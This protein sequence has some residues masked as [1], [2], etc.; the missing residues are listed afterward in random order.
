MNRTVAHIA[1][2]PGVGRL[3]RH[4]EH[5]ERSRC[6][7]AAPRFGVL[8]SVQ[9]DRHCDPFDQGDIGSCTGNAMAGACMTG[10]LFRPGRVLT[11]ANAVALYEAA[12]RLDGITGH[13]PPDD[14]GS[15]GLAVAKAAQRAGLISAYHHAFG[16]T[17]S[18]RALAGG[19]VI[20][21]VNWYE[22]F[23]APQGG[24]A[25]LVVSGV[26]RGGHELVL[27]GLDVE[28]GFVHGTNSWGMWGNRGK[29]VMSF[30]TFKRLLAE[31]GDVVAP[32]A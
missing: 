10:P 9:W 19:P 3:G 1:E 4:V 11:E 8:K 6:F 2:H 23:D 30:G 16:L 29:F 24:A 28:A 18:L 20:I 32:V 17:A 27:D 25:E 31:R 22:G 12:T 13:Y 7:A 21:G 15:S 26:V 14:T 5:D